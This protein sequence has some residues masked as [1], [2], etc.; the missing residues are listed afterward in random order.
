MHLQFISLQQLPGDDQALY[1]AGSFSYKHKGGIAVIALN[2][3][4]FSVAKATMITCGP[5]YVH[6]DQHAA[7]G[8]I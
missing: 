2:I 3:E 6:G 8:M 1:L 7:R 5:F 4:F